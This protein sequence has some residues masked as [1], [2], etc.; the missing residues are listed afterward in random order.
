MKISK[1]SIQSFMSDDSEKKKN[2]ALKMGSYLRGFL[3][4]HAY[5]A[6]ENFLIIHVESTINRFRDSSD[7]FVQEVLPYPHPFELCGNNVLFDGANFRKIP[8]SPSRK[9]CSLTTNVK[10]GETTSYMNKRLIKGQNSTLD[11]VA[12]IN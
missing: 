11:T 2:K 6:V 1:K 5:I 12:L 8:I 7:L 3:N 4:I 9:K 10:C